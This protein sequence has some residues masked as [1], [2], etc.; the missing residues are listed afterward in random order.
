MA[1]Q[2]RSSASNKDCATKVMTAEH[3]VTAVAGTDYKSSRQQ[4]W[5][6][7]Q[8]L[9]TCDDDS[10]AAKFVNSCSRDKQ[11]Y[12]MTTQEQCKKQRPGNTVTYSRVLPNRCSRHNSQEL[13]TAGAC[14]LEVMPAD[15][16]TGAHDNTG[17]G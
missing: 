4:E 9:R 8:G 16:Q 6:K 3:C 14:V 17:A 10:R 13:K 7:Q 2:H 5:R 12:L 1:C 11:Q 15:T